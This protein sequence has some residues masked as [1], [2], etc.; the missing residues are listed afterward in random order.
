[1]K[2]KIFPKLLEATGLACV[3]VGL[4]QGVYG[5]MW[6]ELYLLIGGIFIFAIGRQIEKRIEKTAA[7]VEGVVR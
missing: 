5:D 7:R 1:M 3:I 6:G 2:R 4:V